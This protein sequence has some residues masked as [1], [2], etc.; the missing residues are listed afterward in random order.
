MTQNKW[1]SQK[2]LR[3]LRVLEIIKSKPDI[4]TFELISLLTVNEPYLS[5]NSAKQL[6]EDLYYAKKVKI[7]EKDEVKICQ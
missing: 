7:N 3:I 4:K 1:I 2:K 5:R 6:L